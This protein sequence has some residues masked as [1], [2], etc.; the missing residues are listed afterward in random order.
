MLRSTWRLAKVLSY[1]R[2][3]S[4]MQRSQKRNEDLNPSR[5]GKLNMAS[6]FSC[7]F[8]S[9]YSSR[10]LRHLVSVEKHFVFHHLA[11]VPPHYIR[12]N[13]KVWCV[14]KHMPSISLLSR[15]LSLNSGFWKWRI[16]QVKLWVVFK[17]KI[18]P[19]MAL[20]ILFSF[21]E[22]SSCFSALPSFIC[23]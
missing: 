9:N 13:V 6:F 8:C 14:S 7:R 20:S 23:A 15:S 3:I 18:N 11:A 1:L 4:S 5:N 21:L 16:R 12:P 10:A 19:S 22:F 17:K 2:R